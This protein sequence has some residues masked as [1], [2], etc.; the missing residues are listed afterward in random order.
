[1][2]ILEASTVP[3]IA[4]ISLLVASVVGCP[5]AIARAIDRGLALYAFSPLEP[6]ASS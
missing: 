4:A 3:A 2:L 6:N 1:M 5:P